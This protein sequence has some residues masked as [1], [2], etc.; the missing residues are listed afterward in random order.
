MQ[1]YIAIGLSVLV[2]VLLVTVA[3]YI[4]PRK[5]TNDTLATVT[6][7]EDK[8]VETRVVINETEYTHIFTIESPPIVGSEIRVYYNITDEAL[9]EFSLVR[10]PPSIISPILIGIAVL[11]VG[12]SFILNY[13]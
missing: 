13:K 6:N 2:A 7:V 10:D 4:T 3:M 8:R 9:P 12:L 1:K 5:F 11:V